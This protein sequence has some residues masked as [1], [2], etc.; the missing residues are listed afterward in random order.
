ML[1]DILIDD[2]YIKLVDVSEFVKTTKATVKVNGVS[3]TVE[4]FRKKKNCGKATKTF[5]RQRVIVGNYI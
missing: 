1:N 5:W 2:D 3:M 4:E